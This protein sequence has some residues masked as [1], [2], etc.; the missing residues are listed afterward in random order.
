[1]SQRFSAA[2]DT[3][4]S[5]RIFSQSKRT[6][7]GIMA[8]IKITVR[9]IVLMVVSVCCGWDFNLGGVGTFTVVKRTRAGA[10]SQIFEIHAVGKPNHL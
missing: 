8:R 9:I 3:N 10:K 1:M 6:E 5:S 2:L 4:L 7:T